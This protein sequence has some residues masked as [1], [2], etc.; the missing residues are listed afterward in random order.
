MQILNLDS[1]PKDPSSK[2]IPSIVHAPTL[3]Q[4]SKEVP[5]H[6]FGNEDLAWE[7]FMMAVTLVF[8][9]SSRQVKFFFFFLHICI[10]SFSIMQTYVLV[11]F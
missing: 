7:R 5:Q 2:K 6:L 4:P 8:T 10:S 3:S 9:I 11:W 1:E